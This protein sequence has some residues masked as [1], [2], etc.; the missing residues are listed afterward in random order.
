WPFGGSNGG[1][2]SGISMLTISGSAAMATGLAEA[3]A[4]APVNLK[5]SRLEVMR[6]PFQNLD[7][8]IPRGH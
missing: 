4:T 6:N 1:R 2:V 3:A 7:P 8:R 5:K